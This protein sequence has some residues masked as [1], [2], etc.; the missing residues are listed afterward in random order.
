M[1]TQQAAPANATACIVRQADTCNISP[2]TG[3]H[4]T[5]ST[6]LAVSHQR[7][8]GTAGRAANAAGTAQQTLKVE[9][10][11]CNRVTTACMLHCQSNCTRP[12]LQHVYPAFHAR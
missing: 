9:Q 5:A 1:H 11:A 2:K 8:A 12:V 4:A 7:S 6:R 3:S 10:T